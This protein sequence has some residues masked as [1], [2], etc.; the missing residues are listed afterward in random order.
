MLLRLASWRGDIGARISEG[1]ADK[2]AL[3]VLFGA[4]VGMMLAAPFAGDFWWSD[5]PRHALNGAF[6][7]DFIRDLPVHRPTAWAMDYYIRYPSLTIL[8]YP[9]L[10]YVFEAV[11]YA[12]FGVSHAVAQFTE[13]LFIFLFAIGAYLFSRQW[14]SRIAAIGVALL[15][16]GAPEIAY[17]G[18]Q[19][20]LD[21][22]AYAL[23]L[24]GIVFVCNYL[25]QNTPASIYL[26]TAFFL[27]AVYTKY[28]FAFLVLPAVA[29]VLVARGWRVLFER[30]VTI[31]L[32]VGFI[33]LLPA[34]YMFHRF[35]AVN[36]TA[37]VGQ[38]GGMA[39]HSFGAWTYYAA[40]LPHQLG[41]ATV[42]LAV[43]GLVLSLSGRLKIGLEPWAWALLVAWFAGGYLL[44]SLI[45]H[46]EPR[47]DLM[48]VFPVIV[49][50]ALTVDRLGGRKLIAQIAILFVGAGTYFYSL[51]WYPPPVVSGYRDV[52]RYVTDRAPSPGIVVFSGYRDGNFVFAMRE[53]AGRRDL[54][55]LRAT[56]LLTKIAV[57]R[58]FGVVQSD[59]DEAGI[60]QMLKDYG[61]AMVVV[62]RNFWQDLQA[63]ARFDSV[64]RSSDFHLVASFPVT[65]QLVSDDGPDAGGTGMI[66]I[67][68]PNYKVEPPKGPITIDL[69]II[70][71]TVTGQA[72]KKP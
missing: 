19:V 2:L 56:K 11:F 7:M 65:G 40:Q 42:G 67:Y 14:L 55:V 6:I 68:V 53:L 72:A 10:F 38:P 59:L 50:A 36:V 64:V 43:A 17:W 9:P 31:A 18:R 8:F 4:S 61:I 27:A 71:A 23:G 37:V 3:M 1:I 54:T 62:Q 25:R 45:S 47:H 30:H 60:K 51:I 5:A 69:P 34:A 52:A 35:G 46:K 26:A 13:S 29:A 22:P 16:I 21:I 57:T 15:T 70:G 20:M 58:S 44:F 49:L 48:I 63:M 24:I 12:L 66:D 33:A 39:R 41:Y 28:N 32:A